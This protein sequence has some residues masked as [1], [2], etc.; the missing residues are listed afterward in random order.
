MAGERRKPW[1]GV[2]RLG[3]G[4]G[5]PVARQGWLMLASYVATVV[6]SALLL[7]PFGFTIVLLLGTLAFL[8]CPA[9]VG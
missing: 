2:K 8:R 5:R 6:L 4:V 7:P 3:Y 1:F 9:A